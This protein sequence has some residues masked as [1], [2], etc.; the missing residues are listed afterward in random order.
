LLADYLNRKELRAPD[1]D[2]MVM[3]AFVGRRSGCWT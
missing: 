1:V 3:A 2:Q